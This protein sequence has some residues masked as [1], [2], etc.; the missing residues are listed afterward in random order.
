MAELYFQ[1]DNIEKLKTLYSTPSA[2]KYLP[3][4]IGRYVLLHEKDISGYLTA[5]ISQRISNL[6]TAG[7]FAAFFVLIIWLE[8]LRRLDIF[9][10]EKA[11]YIA[12]TLIISCA[13]TLFVSC[14]WYDFLKFKIDL[15]LHRSFMED[16]LYCIAG[17][18]LGEEVIKLLPL[19][20]I[21]KFTRQVNESI[22]FIIYASVS[23]LGFAFIENSMYFYETNL[24][25]IPGRAFTAVPMHM[26]LSSIQNPAGVRRIPAAVNNI[27]NRRRDSPGVCVFDG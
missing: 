26:F 27:C 19:L 21:I 20:L 9:E 17:I 4:S 14:F 18:G 16:L 7:L 25:S 11:R 8:F 24:T 15:Q 1:A 5:I 12:A 2:R 23:A 10:P 13:T 6:N 3:Y 22:D